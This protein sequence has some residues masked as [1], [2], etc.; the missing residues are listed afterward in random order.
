MLAP[1]AVYIHWPFCLAKCPYCDFNSHVREVID[2]AAWAGALITALETYRRETGPRR[3]SSIFFG[4]GTPSLMAPATVGAVID[5]IARLWPLD[6]DAEITLEANPTSVEAGRFAALREAGVN[7][8]SLGV[9]ALDGAALDFLGRHH[10]VDQALAA[11]NLAKGLFPR[12]SFDLIYARPGQTPKAW[13]AELKRALGLAA[14]HLSCYQL[15]FEPGTPFYGALRRGRIRAPGEDRQ[16]RLLAL[17]HRLC[18]EAG[19]P[20]YEISNFAAPGAES[21]HNLAYWQYDEYLGVGPGAHGRLLLAGQRMAT[22][23]RRR[24]EAWLDAVDRDGT[25]EQARQTLSTTEQALEMIMMGLR[26]RQGVSRP[27][28]RRAVGRPLDDFIDTGTAALYRREGFIADD[29]AGIRLTTTGW[30]LLNSITAG[31]VATGEPA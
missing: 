21:R 12:V 22:S 15:T 1:L 20:A 16:Q 31:L 26:L 7:R 6:G 23:A 11:L 24:P 18:A 13:E 9:Q 27:G 8:L 14:G 2:Q 19:L 30:P 10:S 29:A 17:T 4:G 28:F 5:C 3:V 25:G